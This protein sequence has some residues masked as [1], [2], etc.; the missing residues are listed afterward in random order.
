M[1]GVNV[2]IYLKIVCIL[3][4]NINTTHAFKTR[5]RSNSAEEPRSSSRRA[6]NNLLLLLFVLFDLQHQKEVVRCSSCIIYI[7]M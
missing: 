4:W 3:Y 1:I 7:P 5:R 6:S 2:N